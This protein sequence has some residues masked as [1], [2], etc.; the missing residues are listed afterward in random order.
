MELGR[1]KGECTELCVKAIVDLVNAELLSKTRLEHLV[2]G[3]M[4]EGIV[5]EA[6]WRRSGFEEDD[7][8]D[9]RK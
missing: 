1:A 5:F 6:G 3:Q 4:D 8:E 2:E 7:M 9:D